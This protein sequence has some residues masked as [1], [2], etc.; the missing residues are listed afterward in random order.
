ME[1]KRGSR[2]EIHC[3]S[4]IYSTGNCLGMCVWMG[5]WDEVQHGK[6]GGREN[7]TKKCL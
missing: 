5:G 2:K 6:V 3:R 1:Q 4:K 7:D